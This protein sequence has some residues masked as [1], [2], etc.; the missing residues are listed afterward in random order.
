M[1]GT[2]LL[3]HRRGDGLHVSD[4]LAGYVA[5]GLEGIT[6]AMATKILPALQSLCLDGESLTSVGRFVAVRQLSGLVP[7]TVLEG[8]AS[9][10][11]S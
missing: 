2:P 4:K 8:C 11:V 10:G 5:H 7:V 3:V 6:E 1:V 9:G